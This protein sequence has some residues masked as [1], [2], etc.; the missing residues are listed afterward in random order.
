MNRKC[1]LILLDGLGDRSYKELAYQTPLQAARTP[2]LNALAAEGACGLFHAAL[3][4][5]ALPSENA[6]FAMFGY[7]E[8]DFPG[9]GALEALGAGIDLGRN[10][11][12]VLAHFVS[13]SESNGCLALRKEKNKASREETETLIA[14]VS[15]YDALGV[16]IEF[17]P[18]HGL[19]GILILKGN[20]SR[21][22]TDSDP[23]QEGK[24]LAA[25][26]PWRQYASE[27]VVQ[28]TADILHDYLRRAYHTLKD[29]AINQHR[30]QKGLVPLNAL[31]TQRAGQLRSTTPFASRYGL[32]GLSIA[33]GIVYKGL[34]AYLGLD[35]KMAS[36]TQDPGKDM[37]ERLK[38]A[39]AL[40]DTHDFIHVHTKAPDEAAHA[41]DPFAKKK[42]IEDLDG[43]IGKALASL[44]ENLELLLVVTADHST[45]CSGPLIHSGES[46]PLVFHGP[47]V[48][49]DSVNRFDEVSVA[50]GALGSVRGKELLYLILNHL[51][52]SKLRGIMN[53]P[54]DQPFWPGSYE[55]FR[56]G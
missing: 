35:F 2:I 32:R 20:V 27:P 52:R 10:D 54:V 22:I 41:K 4:G 12:A 48:R 29:H 34:A 47:G 14:A 16:H 1:I 9:R 18:T 40:L 44:M 17:I 5:Q 55:P 36:D 37:A 30:M 19:S 43:G 21:F 13:V 49:R 31:V 15:P 50:S 8:A 45:P 6:H 28:K 38:M 46:V 39:R 25:I 3:L 26:K 53:T 42:V 23:M 33:S 51:D 11:V 24:S 7:E 56:L